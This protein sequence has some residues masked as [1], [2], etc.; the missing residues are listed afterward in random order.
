VSLLTSVK[1][2]GTRAAARAYL[3]RLRRRG[4]AGA[5]FIDGGSYDDPYATY[6]L[7]RRGGPLQKS[8]LGFYVTASHEPGSEILRSPE[9]A[10]DVRKS[11]EFRNAPEPPQ[12][13]PFTF[14]LLNMDPPDHTR[15]R[16]F[17]SRAFT[18]RAISALRPLA[19]QLA[20]ELVRP[21]VQ[22]GH[23]DLINE[24]AYPLPMAVI[25]H[26]LGVPPEMHAQIRTWGYDLAPGLDANPSPALQQ[27]VIKAGEQADAYFT[28][29]IERR[30]TDPGD[31]L[32]SLLTAAQAEGAE[33]S[34]AELLN[35]CTLL[36]LAG[37]VTTVN[38]IGNGTH[39]LLSHPHQLAALRDE[40]ALISNAVDEMLRYDSPVQFTMRFADTAVAVGDV[41]IDAGESAVVMIGAAN[42][43]PEAFPRPNDFDVTREQPQRHLSFASGIHHCL[44]ASLARLEGQV[45]F[46]TLVRETTKVEL[47]APSVR[48]PIR[49]LRGLQTLPIRLSG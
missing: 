8:A 22:R 23:G 20:A 1:K 2:A 46:E 13:D 42:R 29:L 49:N 34:D 16:Q 32:V 48:R 10:C 35:T 26:L 39:A 9:W 30:R 12:M 17:V 19:E 47:S 7:I 45:F 24:V 38:L 43:D 40:P 15:V 28:E 37:F 14:S 33:L 6:D 41:T 44:G 27:Q 25:S 5:L 4:D 18:P 36:L 3:A 31:D 21:M 11:K